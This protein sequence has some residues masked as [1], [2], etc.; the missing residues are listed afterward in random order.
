MDAILPKLPADG[1][2]DSNPTNK[3]IHSAAKAD[4]QYRSFQPPD[5]HFVVLIAEGVA[6]LYDLRNERPSR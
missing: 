5:G 3:S 2:A 1:S 4:D 6:A